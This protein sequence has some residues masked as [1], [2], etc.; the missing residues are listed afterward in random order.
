MQGYLLS[1]SFSLLVADLDDHCLASCAACSAVNSAP[2]AVAYAGSDCVTGVAATDAGGC[3]YLYTGST[4]ADS[5]GSSTAGPGAC[6]AVS[7]GCHNSICGCTCTNVACHV[8][9]AFERDRVECS[10]QRR[11]EAVPCSTLRA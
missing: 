4:S 3:C 9:A 6:G 1:P 7:E 8:I 5:P 11:P 10:D 2:V